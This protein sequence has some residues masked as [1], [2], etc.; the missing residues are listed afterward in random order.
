MERQHIGGSV[1]TTWLAKREK[2]LNQVVVNNALA[3]AREATCETNAPQ[4]ANRS[5]PPAEARA[6]MASEQQPLANATDRE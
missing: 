2:D 3:L 1:A 4:P 6:C 5:S